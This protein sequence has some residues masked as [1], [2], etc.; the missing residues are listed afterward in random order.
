MRLAVLLAALAALG[1]CLPAAT[2]LA[3]GGAAAGD[4]GGGAPAFRPE[5][6]FAGRTTGDAHLTI[7]MR[8]AQRLRVESVGAAQPDG[9]FRLD[10]TIAYP[11]GHAD[12]RTWT[13]RSLG[14]GRYES[15]LTPDA[16]GE[17]RVEA[18]GSTLRIRYRMGRTTTM[19][20][21]LALRPGGQAADNV[22][23]VRMMGVPIARLTEVITR[24]GAAG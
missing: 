19:D 24:A 4:A 15:T 14:A 17:V 22:A 7:R 16:R 18:Q 6:F 1:G 13:M 5:A 8:A 9:S 11:D 21:T 23:T 2:P 20:Q 10:Q 12:R 3:A